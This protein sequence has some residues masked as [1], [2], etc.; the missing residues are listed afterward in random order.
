MRIDKN[1]IISLTLL[2][3]VFLSG[4]SE[5]KSKLEQILERGELRVATR[6]GPTTYYFEKDKETGLEYEL[7]RRFANQLQVKLKIIVAKNNPQILNLI[8][9]DKADIAAAAL[10][11]S[12][13]N[14]NF[15]DFGPGYQWVT[16]NLIYR[17]LSSTPRSLADISADTLN[18]SAGILQPYELTILRH[19]Y[20]K[21][22]IKIH[23]NKD[24]EE[25]LEMLENREISY[26]VIN[27]NDQAIMRH[28]FPEIRAAF[29][30]S[31]PQPL[32]WAFKK[33]DDL[34]LKAVIDDF[35]TKIE[36]QGV[37]SDLI[38]YFYGPAEKFDYVDSRTFVKRVTKVLPAYKPSFEKA[39]AKNKL[40][41]RLLAAVSYQESHWKKNARSPTGVR[42]LMMLT[43]NTAETMGIDNRLD[44]EASITGGAGYL[45]TLINKLPRR[46]TEPD[47][48]WLAL[49]AYNLGFGH[50]EDA[51]ILTQRQG[52]DPDSW[53]NVRERLPLLSKKK[54]YKNTKFGFA[55]GYEAKIFVRNIRR[56]Y[57]TLVQLTQPQPPTVPELKLVDALPTDSPAL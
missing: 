36:N 9:S 8:K 57:N 3:I 27:S 13:H 39:A 34:T 4:C 52:G 40:D 38:E 54:W 18:V 42:G 21:L 43:L 10:V 37:L 25:L 15:L 45:R 31:D 26:T 12:E 11:K 1:G 16:Q 17:N 47:R 56:Y 55:R 20:P 30:I 7:A 32:A 53:H 5:P 28:Y 46:I 6:N 48:T 24:V 50:L 22:D 23:A 49:A 29:N 35:F 2:C 19:K 33:S 51:R 44:P 41:W 14:E